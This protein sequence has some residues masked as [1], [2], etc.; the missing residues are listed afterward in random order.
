MSCADGGGS[1]VTRVSN[2]ARV[3]NALG[4][5]TRSLDLDVLPETDPMINPLHRRAGRFVRPRGPLAAGAVPDDVVEPDP[6][7]AG[8]VVLRLRGLPE[9]IHADGFPREVPVTAHLEGSIARG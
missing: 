4:L 2:R 3:G 5:R 7:R 9:Q 8:Q 1:E 6:V